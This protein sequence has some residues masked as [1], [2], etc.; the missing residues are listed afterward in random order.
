MRSGFSALVGLTCFFSTVAAAPLLHGRVNDRS[1]MRDVMFHPALDLEY[2]NK[3]GAD[4]I[5]SYGLCL[6]CIFFFFVALG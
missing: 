4:K 1:L 3:Y 5:S 2:R 6:T